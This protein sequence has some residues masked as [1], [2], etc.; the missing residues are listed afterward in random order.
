MRLLAHYSQDPGI[1]D[2]FMAEGDFF[3]NAANKMY[4]LDITDKKFTLPGDKEPLRAK[5]K[6]L[7][8]GLNYGEGPEKFASVANVPLADAHRMR[9][10]YLNTFTGIKP[11]MDNIQVEAKMRAAEE[12][13]DPYLILPSGRREVSDPYKTYALVNYLI[14][15]SAA[16]VYKQALIELDRYKLLEYLVLPIHDEVLLDV[17]AQD[18]EEVGNECVRIMTRNDYTVP[19]TCGLDILDR[20][21]DKYA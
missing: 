2:A 15:G 13:T 3:I 18:A 8:Y 7:A 10:E 14:Q 16:D 11:F 1:I 6:T 4:G 17:P 19:L 21:G 5:L 20:W 12:A 9:G